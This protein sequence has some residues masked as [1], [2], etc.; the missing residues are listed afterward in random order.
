MDYKSEAYSVQLRKEIKF[1]DN[2]ENAKVRKERIIFKSG[3]F[4]RN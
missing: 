1:L 3:K 4:Y 2:L